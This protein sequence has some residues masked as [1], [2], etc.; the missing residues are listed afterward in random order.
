MGFVLVPLLALLV[1]PGYA[2]APARDPDIYF[3]QASFRELPEE[4]QLAA[5]GGQHGL[6]IMF[7][8]ED[9]SPCKRMKRDILSQ[10]Q[11][12]DYFRRHFRVLY[13]DFNGDQRVIDPAGRQYTEKEYAAKGVRIRGTPGFLFLGLKGEELA[14]HY[15]GLRSV[16]EFLLLGEFVVSGAHR[17]MDFKQYRSERQARG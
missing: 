14:R 16:E 13:L 7:G 2:A 8:A 1:Q 17:R 6:A 10:P 11:V 5:E 15:G 12:Q 3:F 4:L 9:C